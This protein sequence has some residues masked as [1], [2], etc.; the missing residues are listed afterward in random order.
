[1]SYFDICFQKD[2]FQ[3]LLIGFD[4]LDQLY[5]VFSTTL[6]NLP[7]PHG[8]LLQDA[9]F[10][11]D[12]IKDW[13]GV[14]KL[15]KIPGEIYTGVE[16]HRYRYSD[17]K[18]LMSAWQKSRSWSLDNRLVLASYMGSPA[19]V[20]YLVENGANVYVLSDQQRIQYGL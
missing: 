10:Y 7:G 3:E 14:D 5:Q 20:K 12:K 13:Y 15:P 11:G 1:M 6:W 17:E 2:L 18:E 19:L 9:E 4:S 16:P 8:R